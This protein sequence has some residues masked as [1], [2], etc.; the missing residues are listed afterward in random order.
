MIDDDSLFS[1]GHAGPSILHGAIW[2][3]CD[4]DWHVPSSNGAARQSNLASTLLQQKLANANLG[5]RPRPSWLAEI[6]NP[7]NCLRRRGMVIL[8]TASHVEL[9]IITKF[10]CFLACFLDSMTVSCST[11]L[12]LLPVRT[13]CTCQ[14]RAER[15]ANCY[16]YHCTACVSLFD[17]AVR[18]MDGAPN[19]VETGVR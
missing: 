3:M 8:L 12:L 11:N 19:R 2:R 14:V 9:K 18:W 17:D 10:T 4:L 5:R 16:Y 1:F 7:S 6:E 13:P 15:S